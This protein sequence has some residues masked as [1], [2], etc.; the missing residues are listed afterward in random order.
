L[1]GSGEVRQRERIGERL[2]HSAGAVIVV[3]MVEQAHLAHERPVGKFKWAQHL[4]RRFGGGGGGGGGVKLS[5]CACMQP[6]TNI[7]SLRA[8]HRSPARGVRLE[9]PQA[10][11]F[12][13]TRTSQYI[14]IVTVAVIHL[15]IPVSFRTLFLCANHAIHYSASP[16]VS[17]L[18]ALQSLSGMV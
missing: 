17:C 13:F 2:G 8:K 7:T 6:T 14:H 5:R 12:P 15:P 3:M 11:S 10:P 16:L 9:L 18:L 4:M 1:G